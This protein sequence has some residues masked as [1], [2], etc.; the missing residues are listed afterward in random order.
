MGESLVAGAAG[1]MGTDNR[2]FIGNDIS[3]INILHTRLGGLDSP[4]IYLESQYN[5]KL[6]SR[7]MDR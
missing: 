1:E 5:S 2:I 6:I 4:W 7:E 3:L